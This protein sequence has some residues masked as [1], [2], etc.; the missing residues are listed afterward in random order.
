[1]IYLSCPVPAS[2]GVAMALFKPSQYQ[3]GQELQSVRPAQNSQHQEE[4]PTMVITVGLLKTIG[5]VD[6]TEIMHHTVGSHG[7]QQAH[8]HQPDCTDRHCK[9]GGAGPSA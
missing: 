4:P 6:D 5:P 2:I 3:Q 1:M 9:I 8:K 7:D